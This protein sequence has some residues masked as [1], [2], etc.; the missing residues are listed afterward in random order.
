M[1]ANRK[2]VVTIV[3]L[4]LGIVG[5]LIAT[6]LVP[7]AVSAGPHGSVVSVTADDA[8]ETVIVTTDDTHW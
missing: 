2:F 3:S 5:L 7:P 1:S 4:L 8:N 6:A